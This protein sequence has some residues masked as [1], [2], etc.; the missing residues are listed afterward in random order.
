MN[1]MGWCLLTFL[2]GLVLGV[3]LDRQ[4]ILIEYGFADEPV[5]KQETET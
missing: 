4:K 1:Q 2:L 5:T 3:M